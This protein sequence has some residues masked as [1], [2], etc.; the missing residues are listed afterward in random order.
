AEPDERGGAVKDRHLV[1]RRLRLILLPGTPEELRAPARRAQSRAGRVHQH[2]IEHGT[3]GRA[4]GILGEHLQTRT[5]TRGRPSDEGRPPRNQIGPDDE[6]AGL[7]ETR[8]V[9]CLPP[10]A[11]AAAADSTSLAGSNLRSSPTAHA[12]RPVRSDTASSSS[13]R[14]AGGGCVASLRRTAFTK[15]RW[16]GRASR[17]DSATAAWSGTRVNPIWYAPSRKTSRRSTSRAGAG[18]F[19]AYSILRSSTSFVRSIPYASSDAN[20]R[21]RSDS[22]PAAWSSAASVR[23]EYAPS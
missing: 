9:R 14:G 3:K 1:S 5:E 11:R 23:F 22:E 21:S 13:P 16:R 12:A 2:R 10:G 18:R 4:T 19:A 20:R 6:P 7:S 8:R 15:P 17:T